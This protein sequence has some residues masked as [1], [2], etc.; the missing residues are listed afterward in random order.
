[1]REKIF[2]LLAKWHASHPWRI[3]LVL[4]LITFI[5]AGFAS[6]LTIKMQWSDLLPEGDKRSEQFNRI[7]EEFVTSSSLVVVVQG[8]EER[9]KEFADELAPRIRQSTD[10]NKNESLRKKINKLQKKI[11][12][13]K[14]KPNKNKQIKELEDKI[15][16]FQAKIDRKL[17]QRVDYKAEL[18]FLKNHGLMLVKESDL[19]NLKDTFQDPNLNGLLYNINNAMEKEYVGQEESLSTREKED[20][21][22]QFLDGIQTFVLTLQKQIF[23]RLQTSFSLANLISFPTIKKLS[24]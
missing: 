10:T 18:D 9:I 7:I 8:E 12:S 14:K 3:F 15:N 5:L 17:F 11:E 23:M 24:L 6:R 16:S 2:K 20:G 4:V 19:K 21:A 22:W 13:L 1:M